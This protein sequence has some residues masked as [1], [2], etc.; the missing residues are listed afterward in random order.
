[1]KNPNLSKK[2]LEILLA[3]DC[4]IAELA[5]R[6]RLLAVVAIGSLKQFL[7]KPFLCFLQNIV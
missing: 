4:L 7:Q 6:V 3:F 1:L 2:Y 5:T